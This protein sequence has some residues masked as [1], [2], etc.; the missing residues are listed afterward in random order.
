[1]FARKRKKID[2]TS[3]GSLK[4]FPFKEICVEININLKA[5]GQGYMVD[6]TTPNNLDTI[7][8]GE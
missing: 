4:I 3:S 6:V 2:F 8:F 1:M 5:Q 7:I